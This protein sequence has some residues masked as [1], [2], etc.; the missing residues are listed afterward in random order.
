[1]FES[2]GIFKE[3]AQRISITEQSKPVSTPFTPHFKL[4]SSLSPSMDE[5]RKYMSKVLYSNVVGSLMYI[6]VCTRP[7]I[8]LAIGVMNRYMHDLRKR[9]W[10]VVKWIL[11]YILNTVDVGLIF[12]RDD[13]LGQ[14]VVGYVDSAYAGDLDRRRSTISY[15]FTLA[16]TSMS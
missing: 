7:D 4:C 9:H 15:V 10:Q 11:R 2:E 6:M 1:M 14:Y 3:G 16:K 13:N 12:E 5:E 8:S